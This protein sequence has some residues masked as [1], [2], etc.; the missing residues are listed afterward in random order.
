M[1]FLV[2]PSKT[3]KFNGRHHALFSIPQFLPEASEIIKNLSNLSRK[4]L[5]NLLK[6]NNNLTSSVYRQIHDF[7][8]PFSHENAHQALFV[9]QGDAYQKMRADQYLDE[10]LQY[11]QDH[12]FI[13]S[14]LFGILRPMDLIQPYRLEMA[15][16]LKIAGRTNLYQ[17]WREKVTNHLNQVLRHDP[18]PI[19]INLASL[20]YVKVIDTQKLTAPMVQ[21]TFQQ[22]TGKGF[23]TIA[24]HTKRARGMMVDFAIRNQ[25]SE[26]SQLK[27]FSEEGYHYK[28]KESSSSNFVFH[29][30]GE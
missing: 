13:L 22:R 19:C 8:V 6:T 4:E 17:L 9:Y 21:I 15:A 7:N 27:E 20:E 23:K 16:S 1:Q 5:E 10:Q 29:Q 12:L 30:G 18:H 3:Q 28:A 25:I 24:I 11:A 2:A 26:L 14:G